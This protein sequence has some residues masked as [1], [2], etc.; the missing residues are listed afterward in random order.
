MG[1]KQTIIIYPYLNDV[2]GDISVICEVEWSGVTGNAVIR[3]L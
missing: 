3:N 1:R 2:G